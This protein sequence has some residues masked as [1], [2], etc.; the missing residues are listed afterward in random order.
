MSRFRLLEARRGLVGEEEALL[1][2]L[3]LTA[4]LAE[5]VGDQRAEAFHQESEDLLEAIPNARFALGAQIDALIADWQESAAENLRQASQAS[6]DIA[7]RIAAGTLL[8]AK[9]PTLTSERRL[10]ELEAQFKDQP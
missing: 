7:G 3:A 6:D 5:R 1:A 2:S 9:D 10:A 4:E 8:I